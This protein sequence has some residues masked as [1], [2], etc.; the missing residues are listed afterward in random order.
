MK[1]AFLPKPWDAVVDDLTERGHT[2]VD[3]NESPDVLVFRGSPEEFPEDLPPSVKLVQVAYAGVE[4]LVEAGVLDQA[5]PVANAAGIYD[6]TVAES[7][8]ALLLGVLQRHKAVTPRWNEQQ[9]F[10]EKDYLFDNKKVAVIGAGGIGKMLIRFL[11]PFGPE[12]IAVNRSGNPVPGATRTVAMDD[13]Q[14]VWSEADYFV[15]IAP[16]TKQTHHMVNAEVLRAMKPNAVVVNVGR[17]PLVDTEALTQ[18]LQ[19]GT[20]AGAG[21]DVTDP[22]PLPEDHPLWQMDRCLI[23]LHTANIPRYMQARVGELT[24]RNWEALQ[25]GQLMPTQ[26]DVE[27]GY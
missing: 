8:L 21:L 13:A 24:R 5:V 2:F 11:E 23:T 7:A 3:L 15:L 26:I 9:M 27:E 16:L 22:E 12:I 25:A 17:G 18:A 14:D 19:E 6:D 20:I 10:E 1:F 4:K